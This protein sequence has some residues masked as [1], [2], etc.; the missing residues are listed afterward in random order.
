MR[1]DGDEEPV[2][3]E[4]ADSETGLHGRMQGAMEEGGQCDLDRERSRETGSQ[5]DLLEAL[6]QLIP[7]H[8]LFY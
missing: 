4:T 6:T 5:A 8:A 3:G 1:G 2:N 7:T